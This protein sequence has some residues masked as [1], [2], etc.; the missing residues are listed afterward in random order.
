MIRPS[1]LLSTTIETTTLDVIDTGVQAV[2]ERMDLTGEALDQLHNFG[3][4]EGQ[5][6]RVIQA[7]RPMI[8]EVLRT[9]IGIHQDLAARLHVVIPR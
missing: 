2:I 9:R 3:F 7:G 6:L 8:V 1:A 5:K 4:F